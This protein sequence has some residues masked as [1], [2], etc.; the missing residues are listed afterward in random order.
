MRTFGSTTRL[1]FPAQWSRLGISTRNSTQPHHPPR[2]GF[3]HRRGH[4]RHLC[5]RGHY[6][7]LCR[8]GH[9]RH[10][11]RS[12]TLCPHLGPSYRL[13]PCIR[14]L[15]V[16]RPS[17]GPIICLTNNG[18]SFAARVSAFAASNRLYGKTNRTH[19]LLPRVFSPLLSVVCPPGRRIQ[20]LVQ[21]AI[22]ALETIRTSSPS[23]LFCFHPVTALFF[24]LGGD[25]CFLS[26]PHP[27][28]PR[29]GQEYKVIPTLICSSSYASLDT[30]NDHTCR[31]LVLANNSQNFHQHLKTERILATLNEYM[32]RAR[33]Y[34][35]FT[36]QS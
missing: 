21:P 13:C 34:F 36:L 5:R 25:F 28:N 14:Q 24:S 30:N 26:Y 11:F 22:S 32:N 16:Y 23:S 33:L 1:L 8:R 12:W 20:P 17:D 2:H 3:P 4:Y 9:Y 10:L 27:K 35:Q 7:H 31:K 6:N 29:Y 15:H 19:S 18:K